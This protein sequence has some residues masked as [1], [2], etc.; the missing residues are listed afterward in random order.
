MQGEVKGSDC[1]MGPGFPSGVMKM[2]WNW[3]GVM[4]VQHCDRTKYRSIAYFKIINCMCVLLQFKKSRK[5]HPHV[6]SQ[7]RSHSY[8]DSHRGVINL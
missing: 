5:A 1:L 7:L 3:R 4:A 2:F 6:F 8:L